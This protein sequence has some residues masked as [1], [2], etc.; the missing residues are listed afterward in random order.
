MSQD[1]DS[2]EAA[3]QARDQALKEGTPGFRISGYNYRAMLATATRCAA[4]GCSSRLVHYVDQAVEK[5][6]DWRWY[7]VYGLGLCRY[8]EARLL[9]GFNVAGH[10]RHT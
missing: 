9:A 8:H 10:L 3:W 7:S 4:E 5:E 1:E 6:G 2:T